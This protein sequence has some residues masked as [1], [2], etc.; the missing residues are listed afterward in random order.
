MGMRTWT[1]FALVL[2]LLILPPA[3]LAGTPQDVNFA[4]SVYAGGLTQTT[5]LAW[6]T[7][8]S[9]TLF[10]AQKT[11]ALRVVRNG[12]LQSANVLS[13]PVYTNSECGLIGLA[14]HPSYASNKFIYVFATVSS[15]V[16]RIFRYTIATDGSGNLV[17]QSQTQIGPDLPT[18]GVNHDGGSL[19]IGPDGNLYFGVGNCGN[20]NNVGGDGTSGELTSLGSKVGRMTQTGAAVSTNPWY[21]AG[22]GISATDYVFAK[23]FR[24]PFGLRFHPTTGALWMTEVGDGWEQIFLVTAGSTQGWPTENNTSTTNGKL[25]P[26]LAYQTNVSTFGGCITRGVFYTGATFPSQYARNLFFCDYNSGKVMRCV[27]DASGNNISNTSVFVSGNSSL[28]DIAQGP[29]GSLYYASHNGNIYRLAYAPQTPQNILLSTTSLSVN[30]ASSATFTVKLATAPASNVVVN[31][32]RTSGTPEITSSPA[33]LTFTPATW[34]TPQT[35]AVN[36][37]EDADAVDEGATITCTASGLASQKVVVTLRDNERLPSAPRATIT[38]PRN[39]DTVSGSAAEFYG[40]GLDDVGCVRAEFYVDGVLKYSDV[41][42][43]NHYHIGGDHLRWDTTTLTNGTHLLRMTVYDGGGQ[44]GSHEVTVT[45]NNAG[46]SSGLRGD[47]Y[48]NSDFTA[49]KVG[50]TDA[51]VNFNWGSGS[52]DASMG[53]DTFSVRWTGQVLPQFSETYTFYTTSDDGV[54]LWV[55][56]QQVI[57]NWTD[58]APTENSGA[59]ALVANRWTEIKM[60]FYENGGGA[61]ATLSWSSPSRPK[62]IIPASRLSPGA[63]FKQDGGA[64]GLASMEAENFHL[65]VSR[66]GKSWVANSTSGFSGTGA[67]L[68]SPNTGVNQTTG[69]AASSPRLD[70]KVNF[71]K[72]GTHHV[73]VRGI[74]ASGSDD[75]C[76]VGLDGAEASTAD[77]ISSFGTGWTWSRACMDGTSATLNI[78]TPG[79]HT[80]NVWM[81]EDGFVIDKLFLTVNVTYAPSGTGPAQS[82]K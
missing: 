47:Y 61:T 23:G 60:E 26:K 5:S 20:G 64:D 38:Q 82:P 4:E 33:S 70:F 79:V 44:N 3:L 31:V 41:N 54:R 9:S 43:S 81:R 69:Y 17:G 8:G 57:N 6:A 48:D 71:V 22:D 78:A 46:M 76:H 53:V 65:N 19:A 35:V 66:N 32:A 58:H 62:E 15:S 30:E 27:M 10:A 55:N 24:N 11:G 52:P 39:G 16:Q 63:S 28:T 25:I 50:R 73:W 49:F 36:A 21:N 18:M 13:I 68:A 59:I 67:L 51:T 7:D 75:S 45:V 37:A 12:T 1:A 74:G 14:V 34:N 40:D 80:I 42:T 56:N 2:S 72:T 77:A 29:D